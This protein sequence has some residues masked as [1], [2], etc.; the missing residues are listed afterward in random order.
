MTAGEASA[1]VARPKLVVL[2]NASSKPDLDL[3]LEQCGARAPNP[4]SVEDI[5]GAVQSAM[6]DPA[7]V[8]R[9]LTPM[10]QEARI[11]G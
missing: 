10:R 7:L 6:W 4:F 8:N 3:F 2:H 9:S 1:P 5:F 11:L